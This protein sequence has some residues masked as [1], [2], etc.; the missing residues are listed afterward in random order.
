MKKNEKAFLAITFIGF[1]LVLSLIPW[2]K[3]I[4]LIGIGLLANTYFFGY[5]ALLNNQ[6]YQEFSKNKSETKNIKGFEMLAPYSILT[7]MVGMLFKF[8]AWPGANLIILLGL[9]LA[10]AAIYFVRKKSEESKAIKQGSIKRIIITSI[11]AIAFYILPNFFWFDIVNREHPEYIEATK[12]LYLE[13][14]NEEYRSQLE[15]ERKKM[16]DGI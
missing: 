6:S 11:L 15:V 13:P 1:I 12:N 7:L 5:S 10:A 14:E 2:A 4:M 9:I 3:W 16:K 8:E